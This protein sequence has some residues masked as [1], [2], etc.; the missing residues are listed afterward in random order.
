MV[1]FISADWG[2]GVVGKKEN[3][4]VTMRKISEAMLMGKPHFPKLNFDGSNG[5][6]VT[7]RQIKQPIEHM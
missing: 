1:Q 5:W 4:K 6:C 7:L 3:M 2:S